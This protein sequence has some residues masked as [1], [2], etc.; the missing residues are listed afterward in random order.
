MESEKKV[1]TQWVFSYL[2]GDVTGNIRSEGV[3]GEV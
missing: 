3:E 1:R 2:A